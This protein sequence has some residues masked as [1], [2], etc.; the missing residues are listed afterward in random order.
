MFRRSC[1]MVVGVLLQY[2]RLVVDY[3]MASV[4]ANGLEDRSGCEATGYTR[5]ENIYVNVGQVLQLGGRLSS[6]TYPPNVL[7]QRY[8][9]CMRNL[10]HNTEVG[11]RQIYG[12]GYNVYTLRNFT[13]FFF[14]L[15]CFYDL[16]TY[17]DKI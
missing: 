17:N 16:F 14:L 1:V 13:L 11:H 12:A 6:P 7:A 4:V 2:V 10:I 3:C 15:Y 5:G 9:G 8:E